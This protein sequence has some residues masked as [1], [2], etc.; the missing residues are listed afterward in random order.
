MDLNNHTGYAQ[1]VEERLNEGAG[2]SLVARYTYGHDLISQTRDEGTS[3]YLYDGHGSVRALVDETETVTDEYE[4]DAFGILLSS[5]GATENVYLYTGE[6]Y[7]ADLGMYFLRARYLNAGTGRFHN[8]D[9]YEGR[10]GEPLTLHKYLYVHNNPVMGLDPSGHRSLF[11]TGLV[12][13]WVGYLAKSFSH[14][15]ILGRGIVGAGIQSATIAYTSLYAIQAHGGFS[16]FAQKAVPYNRALSRRLFNLGHESLQLIHKTVDKA[17]AG[18]AKSMFLGPIG[19]IWNAVGAGTALASNFETLVKGAEYAI[20]AAGFKGTCKIKLPEAGVLGA[21]AR[22]KLD[23][24]TGRF[25]LYQALDAAGNRYLADHVDNPFYA[26]YLER[27][28]ERYLQSFCGRYFD[29]D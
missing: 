12:A 4:Y 28:S 1:V 3:W 18:V 27:D 13:R 22:L 10:N 5:S 11:E 14:P 23:V 29:E 17:P 2:Y 20:T 26:K 7:D 6:Q 25:P 19:L 16:S 21:S 24:I 9:T 15:A 8:M